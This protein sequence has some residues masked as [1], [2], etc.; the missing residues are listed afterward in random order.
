M[1]R[2]IGRARPA[3]LVPPD[4]IAELQTRQQPRLCHLDQTSINRRSIETTCLKIVSNLGMGLRA[5]ARL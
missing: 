3:Q 2:L 4:A 5:V 1:L